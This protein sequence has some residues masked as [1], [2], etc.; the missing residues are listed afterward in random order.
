MWGARGECLTFLI[1]MGI[2]LGM[3][4]NLG[5]RVYREKKGSWAKLGDGGLG[6][7]LC[8]FL[9]HNFATKSKEKLTYRVRMCKQA[10]KVH[11]ARH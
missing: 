1:P 5:S 4:I 3:D 10:Y 6:A 7:L 2:I 11:V 8:A 9:G